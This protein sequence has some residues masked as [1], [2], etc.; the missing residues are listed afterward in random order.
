PPPQPSRYLAFCK[1][2]ENTF[3]KKEDGM[4]Q[5]LTTRNAVRWL[6]L[7]T[8]TLLFVLIIVPRFTQAWV[9]PDAHLYN[10]QE[11]TDYALLERHD[12][13]QANW[14]SG[15][16][17]EGH[18]AYDNI[19]GRVVGDAVFRSHRH[20]DIYYIFPASANDPQVLSAKFKLDDLTGSY[21]Q[22]IDLKLEILDRETAT[23]KRVLS[24][25]KP[26]WETQPNVWHS[27]TLANTNP[28]IAT[29]EFLAVHFA[30]NGDVGGN[31]DVRPTFEIGVQYASRPFG[32]A[33]RL[34]Q[35]GRTLEGIPTLDEA[36]SKAIRPGFSVRGVP[37]AKSVQGRRLG[38]VAAFRS[39]RQVSDMFYVFP[40]QDR[41]AE[42][43]KVH[44]SVLRHTGTYEAGDAELT[45]VIYD[46]QG[47]SSTVLNSAISLTEVAVDDW[48]SVANLNQHEIQAGE[49]LAAR[50]EFT[51]GSS[52]HLD[53]RLQFEIEVSEVGQMPQ[54]W[55]LPL[56]T[57]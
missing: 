41:L 4:T 38:S 52:G 15:F 45:F 28:V 9:E 35:K 29:D 19:I 7:G 43:Q 32:N 39:N 12:A 34:V 5:I 1:A 57:H 46:A 3:P 11:T 36:A 44:F 31:L 42:I 48:V 47:Q 53:L 8:L 54:H 10:W 14:T 51:G 56:I 20:T 25:A 16:T 26:G 27:F 49:F 21:S 40:T 23:V 6:R 17:V 50:V 55:F 24:V 37:T 13:P 18:P 33:L 30:L 22:G 2:I